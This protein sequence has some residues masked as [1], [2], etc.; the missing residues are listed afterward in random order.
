[1]HSLSDKEKQ[2]I[3]RKFIEHAG[4]QNYLPPYARCGKEG[5][6]NLVVLEAIKVLM[7]KS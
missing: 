3:V 1:M 7:F 5:E 2:N 6:S 4:V